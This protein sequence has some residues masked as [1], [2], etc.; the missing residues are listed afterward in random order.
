MLFV[1]SHNTRDVQF[2]LN[3]GV[4]DIVKFKL[5]DSC[6]VARYSLDGE[7]AELSAYK[8]SL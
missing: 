8:D 5:N 6:Y 4:V 2:D 7:L 3:N 1:Y